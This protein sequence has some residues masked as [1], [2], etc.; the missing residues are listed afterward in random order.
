[1]TLKETTT[2][3]LKITVLLLLAASLFT[4]GY[5][6]MFSTKNEKNSSVQ[7]PH[8]AGIKNSLNDFF[9]AKHGNDVTL[10]IEY[11]R[12]HSTITGVGL[13]KYYIWVVVTTHKAVKEEGVVRLAVT[14]EHQVDITHYFSKKEILGKITQIKE[15]FPESVVNRI[16]EK[17]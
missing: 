5:N 1:M 9:K 12:K 7:R 10:E 2:K 4:V 13:P 15:V 11:L 3:G 16:N 17:L 14:H 6:A 8:A